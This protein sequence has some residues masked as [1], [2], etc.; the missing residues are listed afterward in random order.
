[1]TE[2]P[3][4][5]L[6][7]THT[8]LREAVVNAI[9]DRIVDGRFT[10]GSRLAEETVAAELGVSRNPIRE[11][12]QL[13]ASEGFVVVEPRR[14]ARV[15][16]IDARQANDIFEVRGALEG[17]VAA[18]AAERATEVHIEELAAIV[19][20][21]EAAVE[22]NRLDELPHLNTRFHQHLCRI[23]DN[24]LLTNTL[25]QLSGIIRWIYAERL[26]TRVR[27]SWHEHGVL[28]AAIAQHDVE[29]ARRSAVMHVTSAQSAFSAPA[30]PSTARGEANPA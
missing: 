18:L 3:T 23:A 12:F 17:L 11:A 1:M 19:S 28:M 22:Q 5:T 27:D 6:G 25:D 29:A 10:P 14:G 4:S 24:E 30:T 2:N 26:E 15:A 7:A 21:G 20:D 16:S 13:L 8:P 9:R